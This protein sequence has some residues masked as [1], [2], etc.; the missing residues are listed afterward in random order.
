MADDKKGGAKSEAGQLFL[1]FGATG[2]GK[3]VKGLNTLSASF[4]LTK[5]GAEQALKPIISMSQNAAKSVTNWDKLNTVTGISIKQL[6]RMQAWCELNNVSFGDMMGQVQALQKNLYLL[7]KGQGGNIAGFSLLGIDPNSLDI[8]API[9][10]L[11][12]ILARVS[13]LAKTQPAIAANALEELGLS[14]DLLYAYKQQNTAIDERLML[15]DAEINSLKE[16]QTG[17]NTLKVTTS[18]A[19][20]KFIADQS[21]LN[22]AFI[23]F[24]NLLINAVLKIGDLKDRFDEFV[25]SESFKTFVRI[26]EAIK[27]VGKVIVASYKWIYNNVGVPLSQLD[28]ARRDFFAPNPLKSVPLNKMTVSQYSK[29][30]ELRKQQL[31]QFEDAQQSYLNDIEKGKQETQLNKKI[32][33]EKAFKDLLTPHYS[34]QNISN[35]LKLQPIDNMPASSDQ[36]LPAVPIV[37]AGNNNNI[38]VEINQNITSPSPEDAG[39]K[40]AANIQDSINEI[41]ERQNLSGL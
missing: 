38:S 23:V 37:P 8:N 25:Q 11:D 33:R 22:Q 19:L 6:Q 9:Q 32:S 28:Q 20:E 35:P 18:S 3:L 36:I 16:Q 41:L 17:W 34:S 14:R 29:Y 10:A 26:W 39:R 2:L 1:D 7:K 12:T 31:K 30:T 13:Q 40:S 15:N 4:L 27:T 21:W 24:G 5:N